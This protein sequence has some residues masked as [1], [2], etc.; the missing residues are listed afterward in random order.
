M[1]DMYGETALMFASR[2]G[3][4]LAAQ[5][6]LDHG[7]DP[8]V[9]NRY[10]NTALIWSSK[11]VYTDVV[12]LL[13]END[14]NPYIKNNEGKTAYMYAKEED[15]RHLLRRPIGRSMFQSNDRS[16][17]YMSDLYHDIVFV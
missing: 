8:D 14:A 10:G 7:A 12:R 6:L 1:S 16:R 5:L 9:K 15:I 13:L 4:I 17:D 11:Y 2:Y 3:H